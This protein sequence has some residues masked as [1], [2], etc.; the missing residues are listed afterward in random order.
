MPPY[1]SKDIRVAVRFSSAVPISCS[2]HVKAQ[3]AGLRVAARS[4]NCCLVMAI[5]KQMLDA[6]FGITR[7]MRNI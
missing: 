2:K 1:R 4:G 5:P 3:V 6:M 7:A